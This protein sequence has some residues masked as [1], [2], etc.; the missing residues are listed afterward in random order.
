MFII[1][2]RHAG[3]E[4]KF[5]ISNVVMSHLHVKLYKIKVL[6]IFQNIF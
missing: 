2:V 3:L 4:Q 1:L 6:Y 5:V